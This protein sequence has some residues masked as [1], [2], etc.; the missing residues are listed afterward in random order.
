[1]TVPVFSPPCGPST[2]STTSTSTARVLTAQ[3]G[4]GYQMIT[5]DGIN[6]VRDQWTLQ[7]DGL[8]TTDMSTIIAFFAAQLGYI[9]F[10]WQAPGDAAPKLWRCTKWGRNP[11]GPQTWTVT[12]TLDQSFDITS[13]S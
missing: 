7:W 6:T 8:P 10:Q 9:A 11:T 1:M 13:L 2:S 5:S 4:D 12:A 3:L